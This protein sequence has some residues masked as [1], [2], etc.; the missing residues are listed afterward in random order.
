M[1]RTFSEPAHV[2]IDCKPLFP[3]NGGA[4]TIS[5]HPSQSVSAFLDTV[6]RLV[7]EYSY[8]AAYTYGTVWLLQDMESGRIYDNIGIE[9]CRSKGAV[10]D[11]QPIDSVGIRAGDVLYA[12]P[13]EPKN[14]V[15]YLGFEPA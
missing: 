15:T 9:Y 2:K 5:Y 10:P 7:N 13:V 8:V 6:Y 3:E 11:R 14:N 1:K 4:L 12:I